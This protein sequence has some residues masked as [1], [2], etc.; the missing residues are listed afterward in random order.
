MVLKIGLF[1]KVGFKL[2]L[3]ILVKLGLKNIYLEI[4]GIASNY[5]IKIYSIIVTFF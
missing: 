1:S 3:Y 4:D 2:G 5:N